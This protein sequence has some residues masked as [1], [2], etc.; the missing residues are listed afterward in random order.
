MIHSRKVL[1][2]VQVLHLVVYLKSLQDI[3]PKRSKSH[4]DQKDLLL[5]VFLAVKVYFPRILFIT[6]R[7]LVNNLVSTYLW[8]YGHLNLDLSENSNLMNTL[9]ILTPF[10]PNFL[11]SIVLALL[12]RHWLISSQILVTYWDIKEVLMF[13]EVTARDIVSLRTW[14]S[15]HSNL[16]APVSTPSSVSKNILFEW[17]NK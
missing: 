8:I 4:N 14:Y 1:S 16:F 10:P 13:T 7:F 9:N 6:F 17:G 15:V 11:S 2:K 3:L 5:C 12:F